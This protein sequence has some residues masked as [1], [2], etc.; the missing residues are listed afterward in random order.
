MQNRYWA[1]SRNPNCAWSSS[2]VLVSVGSVLTTTRSPPTTLTPPH[3]FFLSV[4]LN[5][6][7]WEPETVNSPQFWLAM[8]FSLWTGSKL[9]KDLKHYLSLRF[10]KSSPDHELQQTIRDNLYRHAV[11]CEYCFLF[12][13]PDFSRRTAPAAT[14]S[15]ITLIH[16]MEWCSC[17]TQTLWWSFS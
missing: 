10:Q 1:L 7:A 5:C 16:L 12:V 15:R 8:C 14:S 17:P 6:A 9:N 2:R 4:E 13:L 11:P 3:L